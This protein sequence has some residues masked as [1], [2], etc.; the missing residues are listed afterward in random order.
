[1]LTGR[2]ARGQFQEVRIHEI[3]VKL[4][5][6]WKTKL[7]VMHMTQAE[8]FVLRAAETVDKKECET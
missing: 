8:W 6:R 7:A 3:P 4:V 1:M 5:V 2:K